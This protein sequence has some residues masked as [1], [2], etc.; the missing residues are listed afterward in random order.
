MEFCRMSTRVLRNHFV[1]HF[2]QF[3]KWCDSILTVEQLCYSLATN[4]SVFPLLFKVPRLCWHIFF[5]FNDFKSFVDLSNPSILQIVK[6]Q[7]ILTLCM[8]INT[9]KRLLNLHPVRIAPCCNRNNALSL[10]PSSS[11]FSFAGV[12]KSFSFG[13]FFLLFPVCYA[14]VSHHHHFLWL[15]QDDLI[16]VLN[17]D[18][19]LQIPFSGLTH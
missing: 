10:F 7:V 16:H 4:M 14:L 12:R 9:I 15:L 6:I 8:T 3:D 13:L 2:Q 17:C 11:M 5:L 19:I 1:F 18:Q